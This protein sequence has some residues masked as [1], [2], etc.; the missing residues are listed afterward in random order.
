MNI[1]FSIEAPSMGHKGY[2]S[3]NWDFS[4]RDVAC[5]ADISGSSVFNLTEVSV[6]VLADNYDDLITFLKKPYIPSSETSKNY[7]KGLEDEIRRFRDQIV[8]IEDEI[9][10]VQELIDEHNTD[11]RK[12]VNNILSFSK[13]DNLQDQLTLL[14]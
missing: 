3:H 2:I 8:D 5:R 10:A 1:Q 6:K 12:L 13:K 14:I 4:T 9:Y 7:I 11:E